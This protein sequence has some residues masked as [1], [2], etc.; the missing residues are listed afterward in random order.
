MRLQ[1]SGARNVLVPAAQQCQ[2]P[3][4]VAVSIG[5]IVEAIVY[6]PIFEGF[7][8]RVTPTAAFRQ[9]QGRLTP[10]L[11]GARIGDRD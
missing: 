4:L 2:A 11:S 7:P 3:T 6:K 8:T 5:G 1:M 9:R 10:A